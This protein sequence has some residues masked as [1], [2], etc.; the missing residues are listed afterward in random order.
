MA[1]LEVVAGGPFSLADRVTLLGLAVALCLCPLVFWPGLY[2]DFTLLK[3][4]SLLV[5][6]AMVLL[7]LAVS[8]FALPSH[9]VFWAGLAAWTVV[10]L[11]AALAGEDPAGGMLGVY[12]YR[13]GLLTQLGYVVLCAGAARTASAAG[14]RALLSLPLLGLAGVTGYTVIQGLGQD[15]VNW[16][17]DTAERAIGTI[18]NANEL[19]GYAAVTLVTMSAA[20]RNRTGRLLIACIMA[21]V[22]FIVVEAESRSGV[23][24]IAAF[25]VAVPGAWIVGKRPLRTLGTPG[26]AVAAGGVAGL[27]LSVAAGWIAGQ[28]SLDGTA[29]RIAQPDRGGATRIS[30]WEGTLR[31]VADAPLLGAGP[32]GLWLTFPRHR[33]E[34]LQGSFEEY[35]LVAQSS[36]NILLDTAANTGLPGVAALTTVALAALAPSIRRRRNQGGH[37]GPVTWEFVWAGLAAYF[38]ML[39][40]N[41]ISLA[42]H[43]VCFMALGVM[44]G[45]GRKLALLPVRRAWVAAI[46][47]VGV[48]GAVVSVA[49]LLPLA[50]LRAQAGYESFEQKDFEGAASNYAAAARLL[51]FDRWYAT[52]R[53]EALLSASVAPTDIGT[54]ATARGAYTDL[55]K[56]FGLSSD[57]ALYAGAAMLAAGDEPAAIVEMAQRAKALNPNGID[58]DVR[59]QAL[60]VSARAGGTLTLAP[61]GR[62][63]VVPNKEEANPE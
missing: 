12:Q 58:I 20:P 36:H 57:D 63:V 18:G 46:P 53:A 28:G 19:A 40:L 56:R 11:L 47:A 59:V 54:A 7:G 16:W 37:D 60:L 1:R 2:D 24:A 8:R 49:V 38:V 9:P 14:A 5:A 10:L 26:L 34:K 22:V 41:P 61:N 44:A 42:A 62:A 55:D 43:A 13:Q 31:T 35:D 50:D 17:T 52:R 3:Q 27:L 30:L 6:A 21:C 33:P 25:L 32:D 39:L 15:P 4:S 48:A 23:L 29:E 51:P 45:D